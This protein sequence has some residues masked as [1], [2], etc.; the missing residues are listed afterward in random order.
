MNL[1]TKSGLA[2]LET[3]LRVKEA[4]R[5][6]SPLVAIYRAHAQRVARWVGRLGGPTVDL[7]DA[8]QEVFIKVQG[9]LAEFRG[10]AE[11]TTWL[12]RITEN[13]VRQRRRRERVRRWFSGARLEPLVD[14]PAGIQT[15]LEALE[16]R[17]AG[18]LVYHVLDG[19]SDPHRSAIIWF[20]LEGLSSDEVATLTG[21]K[22]A[23]LRVRLHRARAEF[24]TRLEVVLERAEAR[25]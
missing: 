21:V 18:Q 10:E 24:A 20:D 8:V 19:M 6:D 7:E 22:A 4:P 13:V 12:Y 25:R 9:L 14:L 17:E 23:T 1:V 11:L 15:P 3:V 16:Q 5:D 2:S